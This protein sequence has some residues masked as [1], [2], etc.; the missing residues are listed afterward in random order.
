MNDFSELR[1]HCSFNFFSSSNEKSNKLRKNYFSTL[2]KELNENVEKIIKSSNKEINEKIE[3]FI[4][5]YRENLFK[6][7]IKKIQIIFI[8][9]KKTKIIFDFFFSTTAS[10]QTLFEKFFNNETSLNQIDKLNSI[11]CFINSEEINNLNKITLK[12]IKTLSPVKKIFFHF[13]LC[14]F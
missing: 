14:F 7:E 13:L 5:N 2:K 6:N 9:C 10:S 1:H 4:E 3:N 12:L 8:S 11:N